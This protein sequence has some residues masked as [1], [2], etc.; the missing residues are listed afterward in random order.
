MNQLGYC[1]I[2]IK[3]VNRKFN[4]STKEICVTN[5]IIVQTKLKFIRN[6]YWHRLAAKSQ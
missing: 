2:M 6:F 4:R 3:M 5:S 1:Q